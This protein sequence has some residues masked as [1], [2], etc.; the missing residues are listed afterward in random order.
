MY[1]GIVQTVLIIYTLH[2]PY[3]CYI[4]SY[5]TALPIDTN[6]AHKPL[7]LYI[8]IYDKSFLLKKRWAI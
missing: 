7:E 8:I 2:K 3:K 6:F 5:F 4:I 1:S